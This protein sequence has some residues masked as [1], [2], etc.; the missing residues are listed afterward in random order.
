MPRD[1]TKHPLGWRGS[2]EGVLLSREL[3]HT[4]L[5]AEHGATAAVRGR[6]NRHHRDMMAFSNQLH[7]ER[8]D[9]C[10]LTRARS[11]RDAHP[12]PARGGGIALSEDE[13]EQ[14][15]G[16]MTPAC[17]LDQRDSLAERAPFAAQQRLS[18]AE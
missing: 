4:R 2:D 17:G 15:I 11:A 9:Q 10:R 8:L 12:E 14:L 7:P 5:V 18:Q 16:L 3:V 1:T 13:L 6:V